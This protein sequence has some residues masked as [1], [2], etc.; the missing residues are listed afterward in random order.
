KKNGLKKGFSIVEFNQHR[1]E[2][3]DRDIIRYPKDYLRYTFRRATSALWIPSGT[4]LEF[5]CR[6]STHRS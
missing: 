6:K 1:P 3:F 2:P 4:F 5:Y